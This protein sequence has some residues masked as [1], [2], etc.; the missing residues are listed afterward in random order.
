M[1]RATHVSTSRGFTWLGARCPQ[2]RVTVTSGQTAES[3]N[4]GHG[5]RSMSP[6]IVTL[7]IMSPRGT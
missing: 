1:Q 4:E 3:P 2:L 6:Q 7:T 5:N